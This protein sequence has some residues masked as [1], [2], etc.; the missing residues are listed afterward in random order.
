MKLESLI[1]LLAAACVL[2]ACYKDH[3]NKSI[4]VI[5]PIVI[6]MGGDR[7]SVSAYVLEEIEIK[8]VVYKLGTDD[9]SLSFEWEISGNDAIPAVIGTNMML[10][11]TVNVPAASN[12]YDIMLT[13]TDNETGLK[14][15]ERFYLSVY[16]AFGRGLVVAD[17]KDGD[18]TDLN[19]IMSRE[20]TQNF[21]SGAFDEEDTKVMRNVFSEVNGG[22]LI[23]GIVHSMIAS[24]DDRGSFPRT[25][26][27]VSEKSAVRMDPYDYQ[28]QEKNDDLFFAWNP[29]TEFKPSTMGY[30][31]SGRYEL[32]AID[33]L[34]Y[35]RSF[36]RG[37]MGYQPYLDVSDNSDYQIKTCCTLWDGYYD[38]VTCYDELHNRFLYVPTDPTLLTVM[39][40]PSAP[41]PFD[42]NNVGDLTALWM[43]ESENVSGNKK[44]FAVMK[45]RT[46]PQYWLLS[47][48]GGSLLTGNAYSA[49][50]KYDLTGCPGFADA[51]DYECSPLENVLFYATDKKIYTVLLNAADPTSG[52]T[53]PAEERYTVTDPNE[54]ITTIDLWRWNY[55]GMLKFKDENSDNGYYENYPYCRMMIITTY[56][57]TTGEGKVIA[58]PLMNLGAGVIELDRN[59]QKE[60]GGFGRITC[61]TAQR[62]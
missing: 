25:L 29:D 17:T 23:E 57:E 59:F 54:V 16:S 27:A 48:F 7:N 34:L 11:A 55:Q 8:P 31:V 15:Y 22:A 41:G 9:A 37:N 43:G 36:Q 61:V 18:N 28:L 30:D 50:G 33:G 58:A 52:E 10:K 14:A 38:V 51:V 1:I 6:D 5:T 35:P 32:L 4:D 56:N 39:S 26:T 13:V 45:S 46:A 42:L 20:F 12:P 60:Y 2:P 24:T 44:T 49:H 40:N 3:S 62:L 53:P 47:Y 19:L 21:S